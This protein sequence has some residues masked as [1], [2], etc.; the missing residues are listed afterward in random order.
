MD[1]A[2]FTFLKALLSTPSPSGFETPVQEIVRQF[3]KPYADEIRS[4]RHGNLIAIRRATKQGDG[5]FQGSCLPGT[6]INL[7]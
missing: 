6:A 5:R 4:D 2:S 7:G 1:D 3:A